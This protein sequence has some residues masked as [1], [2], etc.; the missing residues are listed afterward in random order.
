MNKT[1]KAKESI[2]EKFERLKFNDLEFREDLIASRLTLIP[3]NIHISSNKLL[4]FN[5]EKHLKV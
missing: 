1:L 5:I 4:Y 2:T 3:S